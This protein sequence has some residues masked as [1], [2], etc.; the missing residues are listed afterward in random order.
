MAMGNPKLQCFL[1]LTEWLMRLYSITGNG[2]KLKP[3]VIRFCRKCRLQVLEQKN[4]GRVHISLTPPPPPPPPP[5][6]QP[7]TTPQTLVQKPPRT[8]SKKSSHHAP[9]RRHRTLNAVALAPSPVIPEQQSPSTTTIHG[10]RHTPAP[11]PQGGVQPQGGHSPRPPPQVD[12]YWRDLE[13]G[14]AGV[15]QHPSLPWS[16]WRIYGGIARWATSIVTSFF[17]AWGTR[18]TNNLILFFAGVGK[19]TVMRFVWWVLFRRR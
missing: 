13:N 18:H 16:L 7:T 5:P 4:P 2:K 11:R 3:A 10:D 17:K 6:P 14:G 1:L 19:I 12:E 15:A 9:S 8:S